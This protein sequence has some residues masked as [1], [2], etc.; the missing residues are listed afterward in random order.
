MTDAASDDSELRHRALESARGLDDPGAFH[1]A[2]FMCLNRVP[3]CSSTTG[4]DANEKATLVEEV[5][6]RFDDRAEEGFDRC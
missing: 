1:F 3:S 6:Q 5:I 2:A 4:L